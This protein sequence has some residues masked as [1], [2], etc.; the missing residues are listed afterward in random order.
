MKVE[1]RWQNPLGP[2]DRD[3]FHVYLKWVDR[4]DTPTAMEQVFKMWLA[5]K[6]E[7]RSLIVSD[8]EFLVDGK[9]IELSRQEENEYFRRMKASAGK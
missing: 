8:L 6:V 7:G 4:T 5:E 9:L 3:A 2:E 1:I